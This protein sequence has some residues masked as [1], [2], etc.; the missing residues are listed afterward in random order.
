MGSITKMKE[1]VYGPFI[2]WL[3]QNKI[4][5]CFSND[6]WASKLFDR[7]YAIFQQDAQKIAQSNQLI[8]SIPDD[9]LKAIL[10]QRQQ[11]RNDALAE[12]EKQTTTMKLK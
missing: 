10:E 4:G 11:A 8:N 1:Q 3:D 7:L 12:A 5:D 9:Q 2:E 6:V